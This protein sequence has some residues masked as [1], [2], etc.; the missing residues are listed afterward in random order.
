M[1]VTSVKPSWR[2][3]RSRISEDGIEADLV[4]TVTTDDPALGDRY[5]GWPC[6][7]AITW[8]LVM[9]SPPPTIMVLLP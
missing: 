1:A 2:D 8:L 5:R 3:R 7:S 4:Y 6:F 9:V